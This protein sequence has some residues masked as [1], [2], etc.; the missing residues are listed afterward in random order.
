MEATRI[1]IEKARLKKEIKISKQR[2]EQE[3]LKAEA[4]KKR[5]MRHHYGQYIIATRKKTPQREKQSA[6][7]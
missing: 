1:K 6:I 3:R 5:L 7:A 4:S 2:C